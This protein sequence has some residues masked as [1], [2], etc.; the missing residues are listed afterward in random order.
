[1]LLILAA[2]LAACGVVF[3]NRLQGD[4]G[5]GFVNLRLSGAAMW[6]KR[7]VLAAK[8]ATTATEKDNTT[9]NNSQNMT[10]ANSQQITN[11]LNLPPPPE[12]ESLCLG[13]GV[14]AEPHDSQIMPCGIRHSASWLQQIL[15][16]ATSSSPK[17]RYCKGTVRILQVFLRF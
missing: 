3:G 4:K 16:Q 5:L 13:L 6:P 17:V 7:H 11:R 12:L 15:F 1:M 10:C 9:K 2:L 8:T 14:W